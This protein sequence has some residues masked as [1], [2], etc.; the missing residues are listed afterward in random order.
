[1]KIIEV[2]LNCRAAIV[3]RLDTGP[4]GAVVTFAEGGPP[5]LDGLFAYI[6]R[7]K[8]AARLRPDSKLAVA[9]TWPT[10]DARLN[11]ALQLSRGL[12]KIAEAAPEEK[13]L[14]PA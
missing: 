7:L 13:A 1:M 12:A 9:K 6:E 11:G 5:S 14:E 4:T 3:A 2:K 10:P 8:G